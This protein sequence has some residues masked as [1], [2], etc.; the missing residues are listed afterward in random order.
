MSRTEKL[1][2]IARARAHVHE[3]E[4]FQKL[5]SLEKHQPHS[6]ELIS[7]AC[8]NI[9]LARNVRFFGRQELL[10]Q[11]ERVLQPSDSEQPFSSLLLYGMGGVGKT[12]L[13]L[14]YAYQK[15]DKLDTVLWVPAEDRT[16][17]D[18]SFSQ[19]AL[20]TLKLPSATSS[21]HNRNRVLLLNWL[22]RTCE[23]PNAF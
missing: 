2:S 3:L 6:Y 7:S 19:I 21:D 22:Q 14:E 1:A 13:A 16:S 12:Q 11:I 5:L 4:N 17:L 8:H 9:C 23:S 10:L 18:Q 20:E 15:L